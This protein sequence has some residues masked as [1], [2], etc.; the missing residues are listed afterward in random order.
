MKS[1]RAVMGLAAIVSLISPME[2]PAGAAALRATY[3]GCQDKEIL[4][5]AFQNQKDAGGAKAAA[6]LKGKV[7]AGACVL[8]AKGSQV[9][10]DERDGALWCVRRTGDLD[11]IWTLDRAVDPNPPI[12]SSGGGS[13]GNG[14]GR[15]NHH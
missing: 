15:K 4:K 13:A 8:F 6:F 9:S 11:C 3:P 14:D 7:D 10:I 12:Q 1:L 5:Q 2:K